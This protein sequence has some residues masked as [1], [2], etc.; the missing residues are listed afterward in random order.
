MNAWSLSRYIENNIERV[1][2]NWTSSGAGHL[3]GSGTV[4]FADQAR[5]LRAIVADMNVPRAENLPAG[6]PSHPGFA[7][8]PTV[9]EAARDYALRRLHDGFTLDQLVSE[10]RALRTSVIRTSVTDM[11]MADR[12]VLDELIAFDESLDQALTEAVRSFY[13]G[14]NQAR[15]LFV[16]VL[17]HDLRDPLNAIKSA[18]DLQRVA[19]DDLEARRQANDTAARSIARMSEMIEDLLD[20]SRTRLGGKLPLARRD[21]VNMEEVCEEISESL[22][23]VYSE[24]EIRLTCRG[25]LN[26]S[27]DVGRI[28]QVVANLAKN[29]LDYG[30][31]DTPVL[32]NVEGVGD[33]VLISVNNQGV[34]ISDEQKPTIFDPL[35]RGAF[36][37][38]APQRSADSL[39]LGLY[40]VKEVV[41]AHGGSVEVTSDVQAGTTFTVTLPRYEEHS[42]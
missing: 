26:G 15:D 21:G 8:T 12:N 17:G 40:I 18:T 3:P 38:T 7:A 6:E 5:I 2:A 36:G 31:K 29:A 1:A 30:S 32:I 34:P 33:E 25:D 4:G 39:G 16:A 24:Q 23:L 20:F 41:E 27:W 28:R 42:D 10:F 37:G 9:T 19:K 14:L 13:D 11:D 22:R 35:S